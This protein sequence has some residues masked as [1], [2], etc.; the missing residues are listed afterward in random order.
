[1]SGNAVAALAVLLV[2]GFAG[3]AATAHGATPS[4]R[5]SACETRSEARHA[6]PRTAIDTQCIVLR[7][8][9]SRAAF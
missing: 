3:C 2:S 4:A 9:H 5:A 1:M 6:A 8:S 7:S